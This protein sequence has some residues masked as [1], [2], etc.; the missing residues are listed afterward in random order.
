MDC[1]GISRKPTG[2]TGKVAVLQRLFEISSPVFHVDDSPEVL[3]AFQQFLA[4]KPSCVWKVIGISVPRKRVIPGVIYGRNVDEALSTIL[5]GTGLSQA[6]F[7]VCNFHLS[8]TFA[9]A[10]YSIIVHVISWLWILE[11]VGEITDAV[12]LECSQSLPPKSFSGSLFQK[13]R[14]AFCRFLGLA[15]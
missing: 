12:G 10:I 9:H 11:C 8:I 3:E 14:R 15:K 6:W 13:Y 4:S 7:L 2:P 5:E 1:E